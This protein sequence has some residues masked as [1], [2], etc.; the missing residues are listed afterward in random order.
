MS[1][2]GIEKGTDRKNSWKNSSIQMMN[3]NLMVLR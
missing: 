3:L 1:I 2:Q